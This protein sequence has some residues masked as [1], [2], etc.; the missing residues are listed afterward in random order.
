MIDSVPRRSDSLERRVAKAL[1]VVDFFGIGGF[2]EQTT[3]LDHLHQQAVASF[4][5]MI[6]DM[7]RVRKMLARRLFARRG[8]GIAGQG[9]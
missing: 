7:A 1:S 4:D 8:G 5:R 2:E 9:R 3:H 6:V